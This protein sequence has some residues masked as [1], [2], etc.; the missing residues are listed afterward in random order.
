MRP[1]SAATTRPRAL[2]A[3]AMP[4]RRR[5]PALL[6]GLALAVLSALLASCV[7]AAV[8]VARQGGDAAPAVID[9][10]GTGDVEL[11]GERVPLNKTTVPPP[12]TAAAPAA[13]GKPAGADGVGGAPNDAK[14]SDKVGIAVGLAF[15]GVGALVVVFFC[16]VLPWMRRRKG[17][18]LDRR[19]VSAEEKIANEFAGGDGDSGCNASMAFEEMTMPDEDPEAFT[20]AS[21]FND[22]PG[23][24]MPPAWAKDDL[25][26][27]GKASIRSAKSRRQ[28]AESFVPDIP[29]PPL[30]GQSG[31]SVRRKL[32]EDAAKFEDPPSAPQPRPRL[33]GNAGV[34][35]GSSERR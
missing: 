10:S 2:D 30:P 5:R 25:E 1:P 11:N 23:G 26:T 4:L 32:A 34:G 29:D 19:F 7:R 18:E 6:V 14:G 21:S 12:T 24:A 31:R 17:D 9:D 22:N 3:Q 28:T 8:P 13:T 20:P 33:R 27:P 15:A 35:P 16:F